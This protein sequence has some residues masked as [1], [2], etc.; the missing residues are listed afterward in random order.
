MRT[1]SLS[2]VMVTNPPYGERIGDRQGIEKIYEAYRRFFGENPT[3]SLFVVTADKS[4]EKALGRSAD[5]RRKLYNGRLEVCYYQFHG[6][7]VLI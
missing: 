6:E 4:I 2:G 7:K 5:R 3:W 1:R